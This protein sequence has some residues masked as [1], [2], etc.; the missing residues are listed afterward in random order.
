M[1][2]AVDKA[3]FEQGEIGS[4]WLPKY[5]YM[6]FKKN[7]DVNYSAERAQMPQ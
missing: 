7:I 2:V 3:A 6:L 5:D 1:N 4:S